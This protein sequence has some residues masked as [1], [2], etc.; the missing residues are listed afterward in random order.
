MNTAWLRVRDV[1]GFVLT[2]PIRFSFQLI[3]EH[4]N[5]LHQ[6]HFK[7]LHILPPAL[8]DHES[9]PRQQKVLD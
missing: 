3:V 2:M 4:K 9:L 1:E 5:M 7:Y 8:A 6:I